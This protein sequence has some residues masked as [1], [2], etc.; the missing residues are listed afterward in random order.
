MRASPITVALFSMLLTGCPPPTAYRY[1]LVAGEPIRSGHSLLDA[2]SGEITAQLRIR[3]IWHRNG[4]KWL[5][6]EFHTGPVD[7]TLYLY[8]PSNRMFITVVDQSGSHFSA[9]GRDLFLRVHDAAQKAVAPVV[10]RETKFKEL[11]GIL[12]DD[13]FGRCE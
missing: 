13:I 9:V 11:E 1:L 4:K 10:V 2:V 7:I 3:Q 5:C 6:Q 12:G 8:R